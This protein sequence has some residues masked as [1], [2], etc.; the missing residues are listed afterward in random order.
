MAIIE[1]LCYLKKRYNHYLG[2]INKITINLIYLL[3][4]ELFL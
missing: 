4:V 3:L 2:N 1:L